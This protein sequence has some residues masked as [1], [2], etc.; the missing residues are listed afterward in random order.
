M[1]TARTDPDLHPNFVEYLR[2]TPAR[3]AEV[4]DKCPVAYVPF[5]A[6]EWHGP[7]LPLGLDGLKAGELCRQAAARTG[8]VLFPVVHWGAFRTM[9]FP[10]TFHFSKGAL[11]RQTKRT[12]DQLYDWGF[13]VV[14]LLTGHYPGGQVRNVRR[15]ADR[16]ARRHRDGFA[17]GVPEMALA[18]DPTYVG[19]HAAKFETSIMLALFPGLVDLDSFPAGLSYL[20]RVTRH[21]AW[22]ADPRAASKELG[23]R[24]VD[25]AVER[26]A[27]AVNEVLR[28]R[29]QRPFLEIYEEFKALRRQ[30]RSP[31]RAVELF[32]MDSRSDLL[33][34]LRWMVRQ[35][36][37]PVEGGGR[38]ETY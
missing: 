12:V 22:G 36:G 5:G 34:T 31:G 33:A 24:L 25:A 27:G 6:L 20:E 11:R 23:A 30:L 21:G 26:L 3:L 28:S 32:G 7:H 2:A 35:R 19:D 29:S 13:R 17:L 10:F 4:V 15:A 18:G 14:V 8:G 37:R 16:F 38:T 9:K 1:E